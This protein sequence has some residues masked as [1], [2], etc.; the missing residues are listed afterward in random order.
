MEAF[1]L[2][3]DFEAVENNS[4][5]VAFNYRF[6]GETLP[7][8]EIMDRWRAYNVTP[9]TELQCKECVY[10]PALR[11]ESRLIFQHETQKD[12][13]QKC[14]SGMVVIN[15]ETNETFIESMRECISLLDAKK[16]E[17]DARKREKRTRPRRTRRPSL[18]ISDAD[19]T[20]EK[21]AA[22]QAPSSKRTRRR[23]RRRSGSG[24]GKEEDTD[25]SRVTATE[26]DAVSSGDDTDLSFPNVL[27]S[28]KRR[29]R[30]FAEYLENAGSD[31]ES[32]VDSPPA[33]KRCTYHPMGITLVSAIDNTDDNLPQ[34]CYEHYIYVTM[35]IFF[36]MLT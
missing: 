15:W 9:I 22:K 17:Y 10:L 8:T 34:V 19:D 7:P 6:F 2:W 20:D 32:N 23:R 5:R 29:K 13:P 4:A 36:L 12:K 28:R 27:I 24:K 30:K 1:D 16:V 11:I 35:L 14:R 3:M 33:K 31:Y 21:N 26:S 25:V 18:S